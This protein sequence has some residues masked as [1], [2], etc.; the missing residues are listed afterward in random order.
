MEINLRYT[1][2]Y[3]RIF[4]KAAIRQP[5][6][7]AHQMTP[8]RSGAPLP[9]SFAQ[10]QETPRRIR[11]SACKSDPTELPMIPLIKSAVD[12][13][14]RRESQEIKIY[15]SPERKAAIERVGYKGR[16]RAAW[17]PPRHHNR[18]TQKKES[19]TTNNAAPN[20]TYL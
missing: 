8:R 4:K 6:A 18:S 13:V 16:D 11:A 15:P 12:R 19:E 10:H 5:E 20:R 17:S 9:G 3:S 2:D 1:E 7:F 14:S